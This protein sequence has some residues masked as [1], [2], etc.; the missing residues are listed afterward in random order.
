MA[1]GCKMESK[2]SV[3]DITKAFENSSS[4]AID[5]LEDLTGL[6]LQE[7]KKSNAF[8]DF[9]GE[10]S[11][12]YIIYNSKDTRGELEI[13]SLKATEITKDS[14]AIIVYLEIKLHKPLLIDE[15]KKIWGSDYQLIVNRPTFPVGDRCVARYTTT[16][17]RLDFGF[18]DCEKMDHVIKI[19]VTK[20]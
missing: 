14:K 16:T 5:Q 7:E 10:A 11:P 2:I 1:Y 8:D 9:L 12:K 4:T 19:S 18:S 13:S 6:Q 20:I 3:I 15:I 17:S